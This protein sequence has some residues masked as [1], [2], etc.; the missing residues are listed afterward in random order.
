MAEHFLVTGALGCIGAWCCRELVREGVPVVAFDL[1]ESLHRLE[2][3][4]AS[5]ELEQVTFVRGDVTD[6]AG[7]ERA[8]DKHEITNVI[9]LAALLIPLA[10]E[11]PPRG[12]QVNVAGTVNVFEAVKRRGLPGLAY[13]SSAA[14]YDAADGA[15][16]PE[17][18][19]GRPV[20]HYGVHKQANEGAARIYWLDDGVASVGL[21]PYVVYGPGRDQGLTASPTLAMEAAARGD[22]FRIAFGG[23]LQFHYAPEAARAFVE[24][25][26]AAEEG[27]A[28]RNLGGRATDMAEVVA[29]IE[30]AAPT[31]AGKVSYEDVPLPFPQ[32]FESSVPLTTPLEQGVRETIEH[33]RRASA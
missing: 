29:A 26:R 17:D 8:L 31:V 18:A 4:M 30:A 23:Q 27:A 5:E 21:R 20:T 9:H 3:V 12:A 10:K 15:R 11:N 6:L 32:E 25:A 2:L 24:A 22:G 16:V 7:L 28:V 19:T 33:F 1:G 13:A 14:V